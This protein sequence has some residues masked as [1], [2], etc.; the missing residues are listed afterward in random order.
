LSNANKASAVGAA[1][2][3]FAALAFEFEFAFALAGA[4]VAGA[5]QAAKDIAANANK[6]MYPSLL[7]YISFEKAG[8]S[9]IK[10]QMPEDF[11]LSKKS[12]ERSNSRPN[13]V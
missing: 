12:P 3:G 9:E 10:T 2:T 5:P 8:Y 4:L 6:T 11:S 7:I 13:W 1:A